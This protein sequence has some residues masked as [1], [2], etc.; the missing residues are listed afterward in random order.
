MTDASGTSD[1][2]QVSIVMTSYNRARTLEQGVRSV[3]TQ[4]FSN[5]EL[6]LFDDGSTDGSAEMGRRFAEMDPRVR[7]ATAAHRGVWPATR[8]A[9]ALSRA[10]LVGWVDSDDLLVSTALQ[11]TVKAMHAHPSADAVYTDYLDVDDSL[12]VIGYGNRCTIP[13]SAEALLT[14]FMTFHFRLIRRS[15]YD[16]VGGIDASFTAAGDYD[17]C[18]RLSEQRGGF[19]HLTR[20][21][22]LYRNHRDN[23]SYG[24]RVEQIA[25]TER[26]IRAAMNRRGL[27]G[28]HEL[29]VDLMAYFKV[30]PKRT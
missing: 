28:S 23:I 12:S 7:H 11:E 15:A 25:M 18:L 19:V 6:I 8:D 20:P 4:T 3:L 16:A 17:L 27:E 2:P 21:L 29:F 26:A 9:I 5:F 22:Y 14:S 13:Y 1:T 24:R 30:E 10:P